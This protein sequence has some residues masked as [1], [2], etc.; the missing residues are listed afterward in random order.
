MMIVFFG[1]PGAGKSVQG[2][3][4]AARHG[5]RWLSIGQLL[6]DTKNPEILSIL[7]TGKLLP[8]QQAIDVMSEAI[9]RAK[10]IDQII[11]DGFPRMLEQAEWLVESQPMHGR[12]IGMV[13]VLEV[14]ASE[15]LKRLA[16][17][18]R[19]D[20]TPEAIDE[21]IKIYR[22]EI[23]PILNYLTE[24]NIPIVHIDGAGSVGQVHDKIVEELTSRN[25]A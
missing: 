20:D 4:L 12:S 6:R 1:P 9:V 15:L 2:Q 3:L 5:W 22:Q 16:V 19:T 11:L 7:Q 18:G 10:D 24:Q 14:P 8:V 13:I 23:Y 25:L 17:R 21:R